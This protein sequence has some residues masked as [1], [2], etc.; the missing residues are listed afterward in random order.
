MRVGR[1]DESRQQM[2][3]ENGDES[4]RPGKALQMILYPMDT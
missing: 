4:R 2:K 1:E 3:L